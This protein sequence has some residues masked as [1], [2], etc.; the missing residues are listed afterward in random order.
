MDGTPAI[1]ASRN[2]K[3]KLTTQVKRTNNQHSDLDARSEKLVYFTKQVLTASKK[4]I[5]VS[6]SHCKSNDPRTSMKHSNRQAN[7]GCQVFLMGIL[8]ENVCEG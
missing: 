1:K 3:I 6:S 8:A 5:S 7:G 2:I 4:F